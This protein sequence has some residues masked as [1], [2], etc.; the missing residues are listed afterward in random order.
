[1]ADR[2]VAGL[3]EGDRVAAGELGRR[4]AGV[5]AGG[6]GGGGQV[7]VVIGGSGERLRVPAGVVGVLAEVLGQVGEGRVVKVVHGDVEG[8]EGGGEM[9]TKEAAE[10]LGVSRPF[11][12][13]ELEK[14]KLAYRKVGTHRRIG[15]GELVAYKRR[16]RRERL[17]SLD[18]L[19]GLDQE[20]G[21]Q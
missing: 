5:V 11:L 13:G 7:E 18:E 6:K 8:G 2:K 3:A 16:N 1:M 15:V 19:S 4:L 17:G 9:T 20:S 14:G 12:V 21:L 10:F